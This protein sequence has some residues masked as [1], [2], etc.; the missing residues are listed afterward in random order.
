MQNIHLSVIQY[1]IHNNFSNTRSDFPVQ[2]IKINGVH[3]RDSDVAISNC[4]RHRRRRHHH[5]HQIHNI[6]TITIYTSTS[7][8]IRKIHPQTL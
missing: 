6:W 8:I 4:R 2:V 7:T 1:I 3:S 5:H